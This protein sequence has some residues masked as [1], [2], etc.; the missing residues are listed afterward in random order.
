MKERILNVL[1]VLSVG[2]LICCFCFVKLVMLHHDAEDARSIETVATAETEV[3]TEKVYDIELIPVET[4]P[5]EAETAAA[6]VTEAMETET[7][8][9]TEA[10]TEPGPA[11]TW[12][13]YDIQIAAH[14]VQG[15]AG[16]Q[17][18][19]GKQLVAQCLLQGCLDNNATPEQTRQIMKYAGWSD[20][21]DDETLNAVKSIFIDGERAIERNIKY[22][23]APMYCNGSWHETQIFVLEY[24]EH[25]FFEERR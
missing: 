8:P 2:L 7:S 21:Y 22:F 17:G 23:Y 18:Y 19:F 5:T 4:K 11:G 9:E 24:G 15:E 6:P 16:N 14:I 13:D 10:Y 12:S 20:T 3:E 1:T 25:K